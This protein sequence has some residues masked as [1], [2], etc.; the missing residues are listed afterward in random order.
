M[1]KNRGETRGHEIGV[2]IDCHAIDVLELAKVV[3]EIQIPIELQR[4]S[5]V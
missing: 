3:D 5:K 1:S 2:E 4:L